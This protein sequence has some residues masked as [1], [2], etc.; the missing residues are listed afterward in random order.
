MHLFK[1]TVLLAAL[2]TAATLAAQPPSPT[3]TQQSDTD[4]TATPTPQAASAQNNMRH[5]P[6]PDKQAKRLSKELKLNHDQANQIRPIIADRDQK[7]EQLRTDPSMAPRERRARLQAIQQDS[8]ARIE[9]LLNDAQ[10]QQY[11]QLIS[12]RRNRINRSPRP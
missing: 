12:A 9:A 6:N 10:K 8:T 4:L 11:E 2:V 5:A 7:I 3:Q 1:A